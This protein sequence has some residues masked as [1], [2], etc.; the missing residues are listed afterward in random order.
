M[1]KY[2]TPLGLFIFWLFLVLAA[3][4][5]SYA[6]FSKITPILRNYVQRIRL[7]F[8]IFALLIRRFC[9]RKK[10]TRYIQNTSPSGAQ[11]QFSESEADALLAPPQ[12]HNRND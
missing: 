4:N 12:S 10:Q 1:E 11:I 3:L 5:I 6:G 7:L 8:G 2:F 9:L